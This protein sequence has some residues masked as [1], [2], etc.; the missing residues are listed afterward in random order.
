MWPLIPKS[1][2]KGISEVKDQVYMI[3]D[4]RIT[5]LVKILF[6]PLSNERVSALID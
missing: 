2:T 4:V 5:Q 1:I 3:V 6:V